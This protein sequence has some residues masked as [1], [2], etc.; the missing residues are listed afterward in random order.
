VAGLPADAN[1]PPSIIVI[2][3]GTTMFEK[4]MGSIRATNQ[5][6]SQV[7]SQAGSWFWSFADDLDGVNGYEARQ[8]YMPTTPGTLVTVRF[9]AP[10]AGSLDCLTVDVIPSQPSI[11]AAG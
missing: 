2:R 11:I 6:E 3:D 7:G 5:A 9:T 1:L 10:V 4:R 8:L